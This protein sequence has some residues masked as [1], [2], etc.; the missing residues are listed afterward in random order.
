MNADARKL[1]CA[2]AVLMALSTMIGALGTHSLKSM[3]S[4]EHYETFRTGVQYQF[5]SALGVL[6]VGLIADRRPGKLI[7]LSG[8]LL[9][10]GIILFSG[11]L[12]LLASGVPTWIGF[13]TPLGG[14]CLIAGWILTALS[15]TRNI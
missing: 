14:M 5:F 3:L 15:L 7:R 2:G 4:A 6:A 12:Y 11:S 10:A 8:W 9:C 1:L 13:V